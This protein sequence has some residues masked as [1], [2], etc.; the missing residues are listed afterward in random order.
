M[1]ICSTMIAV[2]L[3]GP[4]FAQGPLPQAGRPSAAQSLPGEPRML[5]PIGSQ[6]LPFPQAGQTQPAFSTP[7]NPAAQ[8]Q[9]EQP[10]SRPQPDPSVVLPRTE[11]LARIDPSLV[12][13]RRLNDSWQLWAGPRMMRDF[14]QDAQSA[15]DALTAIRNLRPTEWAV[16]G[17]PRPVVEY[18]LVKGEPSPWLP[19]LRNSL[20][21]DRK[22]VRAESVRGAW[23]VRD[24]RNILLNFGPYRGDAEQA[25]AVA[26]RYGFNRVG[27][28]GS[29][30]PTMAYY[31]TVDAPPS[32]NGPD[33]ND[34]FIAL[35]RASQEANLSRTAVD[36]PGVGLVGERTVLD[37]RRLDVRKE[38]GEW[39]LANGADVLGR[40]GYSEM[41][42]RDALRVI[43]DVRLTEFCRVGTGMT[44]FL[45]HGQAPTR[46]SYAAQRE[47]FD[48]T[49]LDA[50]ADGAG[51]WGVYEGAGRQLF[52]AGSREEADLVIRV[53]QAYQFDQVCQLGSSPKA[54]LRFLAKTGR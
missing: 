35:T 26:K 29:P 37:M 47:R 21:I 2:G 5:P 13:V 41:A 48:Y 22:T 18:G 4:L 31:F 9:A 36:V 17:S 43:R 30:T 1:R 11:Q 3:A 23:V 15:Q 54:S 6:P 44:F 16:I 10:R 42:A 49:R 34:P 40:F 50:R 8:P 28:I 39:V 27:L 51:G 20:P 24:D 53:I 19:Y 38:R 46:V 45:S 32:T 14:G 12:T 25:A 52:P 7:S 33:E